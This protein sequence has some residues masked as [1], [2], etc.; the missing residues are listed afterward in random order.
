MAFLPHYSECESLVSPLT[1]HPSPLT[2]YYP[3][4]L[5]SL[6]NSIWISWISI[7]RSH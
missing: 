3:L 4:R 1:P 6:I 2:P 7:N 5:T